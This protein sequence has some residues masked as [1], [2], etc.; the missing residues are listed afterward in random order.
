M[1]NLRRPLE[2]RYYSRDQHCSGNYSFVAKSPVV[3][4]L[5]SNEPTQIHLAYGDRIHQMFVSFVTNSKVHTPRCQYGLNSSLLQWEAN[6]TT[7]TYTA[8]DMCEG[9]ATI[10]GPQNFIDP[11]FMH[12]ILLDDLQ[13]STTYFYRVGNNDEGWSSVYSFTNR[14][15]N[16]DSEV[17]LV[18]YGDMGLAPYA[19]GAQSTIERVRARVMS[20]NITCLLHIGDISYAMGTGVLWDAFMTQIESV[21]S[22]VPYM[23][24]IGNHEYDHVTGGD[25]DP[26]GAPGSGGF[27]PHW[28][29]FLAS[30]V[31]SIVSMFLSFVGVIMA[32]IL[33]VNV[34]FRW[35]VV[36]ILQ[37]MA[38]AYFGTVSTLVRFILLST[39]MNMIFIVDPRNI[40]G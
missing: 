24:G 11:G 26:S 16:G 4:P 20:T 29:P 9:K 8:S 25:K 21:A 22:H 27:R 12:T 18:A 7:V 28:Y 36:F 14:P 10:W 38:M 5:N 3:Q 39:R 40:F 15:P 2:F 19:S 33:V 17:I 13:P 6:G 37:L 23:T 32:L 34:L 30:A 35:C 1:I 31:Y